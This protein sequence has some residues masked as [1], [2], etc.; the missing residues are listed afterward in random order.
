MEAD[1]KNIIPMYED[2]GDLFE[3]LEANAVAVNSDEPEDANEEIIVAGIIRLKLTKESKLR[4]RAAASNTGTGAS[5]AC[6]VFDVGVRWARDKFIEA[7]LEK[8]HLNEHEEAEIKAQL[9]QV[10]LDRASMVTSS[11]LANGDGKTGKPEFFAVEN[12][13]DTTK[14]GLFLNIGDQPTQVSNFV[15]KFDEQIVVHDD[16]EQQTRYQGKITCL[17]VTR[18]IK[19]TAQELASNEKLKSVIFNAAPP[20][21]DIKSNVDT[22]RRAI[23]NV[24]H[25]SYRDTTTAAGWTEDGS[26]FLVPGGYVDDQGYHEFH[27]GCGAMEVDLVGYEGARWLSMRALEPD[28][29]IA[30]KKHIATELMNL[31]EPKVM[32]AYSVPWLWL[33]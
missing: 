14:N 20:G 5:L 33:L 8:L 13:K 16:V 2:Y 15:M 10:L 4:F 24:S 7:T 26:K 22:L 6:D 28:Q 23:I 27:P 32:R 18:D 25:Q 9:E 1:N 3:K 31:N 17:G 11:G 19:L 12:A 30:V 21:A 29:L